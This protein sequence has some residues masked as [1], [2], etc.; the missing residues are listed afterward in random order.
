MGTVFGF[1]SK[2][3]KQKMDLLGDFLSNEKISDNFQ[4]V[5]NMIE[6]EKNNDLL[7]KKGYTSGSRT[8]LRLHRGLGKYL[9]VIL[10]L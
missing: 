4:S 8:L 10:H 5:K 3:L 7:H 2:D 6:Y 9:S 1:V